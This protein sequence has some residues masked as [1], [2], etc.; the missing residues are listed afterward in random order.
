MHICQLVIFKISTIK[1]WHHR[2]GVYFQENLKL[3]GLQL[4]TK[5][6]GSN[7]G[8]WFSITFVGSVLLSLTSATTC[9]ETKH[10]NGGIVKKT[11]LVKTWETF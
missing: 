9:V 1:T 2:L 7:L 3:Y 11:N 8:D 10:E 4:R 5:I 6:L